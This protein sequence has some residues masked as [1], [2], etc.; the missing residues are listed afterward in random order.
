M[1][2]R[3]RFPGAPLGARSLPPRGTDIR[4]APARNICRYTTSLAASVA[5]LTVVEGSK[6]GPGTA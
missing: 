5:L 2:P 6:R 4:Y 1:T 3:N